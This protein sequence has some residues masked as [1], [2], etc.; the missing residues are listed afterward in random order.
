MEI[1]YHI[2]PSGSKSQLNL[3]RITVFH[4][5]LTCWQMNLGAAHTLDD[6]RIPRLTDS[7]SQDRADQI[8]TYR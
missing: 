4:Q 7:E 5:M 8:I 1:A 2:G 3:F 6:V